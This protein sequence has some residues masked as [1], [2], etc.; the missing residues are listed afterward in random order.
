M[1]SPCPRATYST[2]PRRF[3]VLGFLVRRSRRTPDLRAGRSRRRGSLPLD[4][5]RMLAAHLS[6]CFQVAR[7]IGLVFAGASR[8]QEV[9]L[10][11]L[12]LAISIESSSTGRR[13]HGGQGLMQIIPRFHR[14]AREHGGVARCST[15]A[16]PVG[17]R[18]LQGVPA[19]QPEAGLQQYNAPRATNRRYAQKVM[20]VRSRARAART[21]VTALGRL[22]MLYRCDVPLSAC[23][24]FAG[25]ADGRVTA[26]IS[27]RSAR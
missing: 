20:A 5:Q 8:R 13:A 27:S 25:A 11:P 16:H 3:T 17:A 6:R 4:P 12:L 24:Q 2:S 14:Q 9:G 22:R 23:R 15:R 7:G 1:L 18:I 10:D 21:Q 26:R 19:R